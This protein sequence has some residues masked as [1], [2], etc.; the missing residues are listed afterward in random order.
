LSRGEARRGFV[1]SS[2]ACGENWAWAWAW[3]REGGGDDGGGSRHT[4][5][6]ARGTMFCDYRLPRG[7][8]S[9]IGICG[10]K[11][12]DSVSLL[13]SP[14]SHSRV[15]RAP[16]PSPPP[17]PGGRDALLPVPAAARTRAAAALLL[18]RRRRAPVPRP[19]AHLPSGAPAA[20]SFPCYPVPR[21]RRFG[22]ARPGSPRDRACW[23][24]CLPLCC[25]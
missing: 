17:P 4:Q 6:R 2:M 10:D 15:S 1:R 24:F 23:S 20:D 12:P 8:F 9:R 3:R 18:P 7:G 11:P 19:R 16:A 25:S 21:L 14:R 5:R 22:L 13:P